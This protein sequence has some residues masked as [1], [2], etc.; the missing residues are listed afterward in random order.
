MRDCPQRSGSIAPAQADRLAPIAQ[1]GRKS[2]RAEAADTSQKAA[3][4]TV[5]R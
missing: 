5:E 3:Y 2:G 4:E 1:R